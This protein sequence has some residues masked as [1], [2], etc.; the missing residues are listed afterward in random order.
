MSLRDYQL[1][2]KR[3]SYS[4]LRKDQ[5][6][7]LMMPTGSGKTHVAMEMIKDGLRHGKR[8]TFIADRISLIDQTFEKFH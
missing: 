3:D 4:A 2:A 6:A 1:Q 8:I 7:M 5:R